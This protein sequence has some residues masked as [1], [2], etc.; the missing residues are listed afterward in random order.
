[1]E[2]KFDTKTI[3]GLGVLT[4]LVVVLQLFSNYVQFGT[5]SITLALIPVVVGACIYGPLG[6][7]FLGLVQGAIVIVAPSTLASFMPI[8]AFATVFTCLLKSAL[9]GLGSAFAFKL[10]K[11]KNLYAASIVAAIVAPIINTGVFTIC[12]FTMFLDTLK[13]WCGD[14]NDLIVWYLTMMIGI[15]FIIEFAVNSLL[16]PVVYQVYNITFKSK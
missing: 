16:S 8:N 15:N 11:N 6:G 5:V 14:G 13:S 7:L 10:L 12:A 4:A 1:M 9:A 3:A 2:K